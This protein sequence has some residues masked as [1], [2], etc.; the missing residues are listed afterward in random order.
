MSLTSKQ[1]IVIFSGAGMSAESGIETFRDSN[2]LWANHKIED[3]ATPQAW[4]INPDLVTDFYNMRRKRIIE[5]EPNDAHELIARLENEFEVN[6]ITQ[7]IDD[8]HERAGSSEVLHLHG[9]I[10]LAKSSGPKAEQKYYL[11][12]G[13]KLTNENKCDDGYRLRPHVVWFGE[14]VPA[15]D[16]AAEIISRCEIL[17]VIGT[18]LMVYPAAGLIHYAPNDAKKYLIDPKAS[19]LDVPSDYSIIQ[20]GAIIGM[21][22]IM[23]LLIGKR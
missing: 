23:D 13:W 22:K 4:M 12:D 2:G 16:L 1:R 19:T 15:Y 6:V 18:S 3:V 9:N 8:L 21:Q 11:I 14:P 5:T 10:R 7:N 17:I 20:S